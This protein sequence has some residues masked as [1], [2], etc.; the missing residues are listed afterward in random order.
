MN[1]NLIIIGASLF[2]IFGIFKFLFG[3]FNFMYEFDKETFKDNFIINILFIS[4]DRTTAALLYITTIFLFSIYSILKSLFYLKI[5]KYKPIVDIIS[6]HTF[7][8]TLYLIFGLL[9]ILLYSFI[10]YYPD[11]ANNYISNDKKYEATY[12][13]V[14]IGSGLVF[15]ITL[16][17]LL[18]VRKHDNQMILYPAILLLLSLIIA[19]AIIAQK[20]GKDFFHEYFTFAM[21]P[22]GVF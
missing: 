4:P 10:A 6:N 15:L 8:Y 20:Y 11:E 22:L 17:V 12:K 18:I 16:L 9:F 13:F 5:L 21:I 14:G 7:D 19:F 2:L 3:I 1:K